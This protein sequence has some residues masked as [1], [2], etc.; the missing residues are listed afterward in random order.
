[1]ADL[2]LVFPPKF[3]NAN[4]ILFAG[5]YVIF[6]KLSFLL[7]DIDSKQAQEDALDIN[8]ILPNLYLGALSIKNYKIML[9]I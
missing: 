1:L 9:I 6:G 8:L 4:P 7:M 3:E 5:S 2:N